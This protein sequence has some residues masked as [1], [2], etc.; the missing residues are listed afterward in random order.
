MGCTVVGAGIGA[1]LGSK[2]GG[3]NI[4]TIRNKE[5][6]EDIINKECKI[7]LKNDSVASGM[8]TNFSNIK[9][10]FGGYKITKDIYKIKINGNS[11]IEISNIDSIKIEEYKISKIQGALIGSGI[12]IVL[13]ITVSGIINGKFK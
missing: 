4:R 2:H 6:G 1:F 3:N 9:D 10:E 5:V 12:G 13:D 8:C 7:F 11:E